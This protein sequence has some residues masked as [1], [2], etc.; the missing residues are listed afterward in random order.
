[1]LLK[2]TEITPSCELNENHK[3]EEH[4]SRESEHLYNCL[5]R[6]VLDHNNNKMCTTHH[7]QTLSKNNLTQGTL[8]QFLFYSVMITFIDILTKTQTTLKKEN[9]R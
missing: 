9:L 3:S 8:I 1:M 4:V 5:H 2:T 6:D 7:I